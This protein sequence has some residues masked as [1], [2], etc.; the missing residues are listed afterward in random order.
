MPLVVRSCGWLM[1]LISPSG[2]LPV[3]LLR[4]VFVERDDGGH[5]DHRVPWQPVTAT[6]RNTLPGIAAR[7]VLEVMTATMTVASLLAL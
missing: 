4:V 7:L 6:G 1:S 3:S 5:V 2:M